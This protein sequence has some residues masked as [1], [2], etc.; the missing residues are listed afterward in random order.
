LILVGGQVLPLVLLIL[1]LASIPGPWPWWAL[2]PTALA[3][4]ASYYPRLAAVG[5]F[6]QSR[7]GA[8]LHPLG[9]LVLVMIQWYAFARKMLGRPANWKGRL[10]P[11]RPILESA[12]WERPS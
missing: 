7:V 5:R 8:G 11:A 10:Y 9:V 6:R 2:V 3:M 4:S 12:H 1:G